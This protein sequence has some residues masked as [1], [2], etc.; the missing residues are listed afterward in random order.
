MP[1]FPMFVDLKDKTVLIAGGGSVALRKLQKL[2]P[3]GVSPTVVAPDI[4]PEL[5]AFPGVKLH[6]RAFRPS[7][8]RPRPVLVIAATNDREVN[9][10]ISM[11]CKKRHI[12]VNVAD[13]P[14]LCSFVFPALVQRGEFS[15]GISTG[16]ASPTAAVYFKERLTELLPENL[17]E[18]LIW[19]RSKRQ[20][21]KA[22]I[23]EPERRAA[24]LHRL[25][26]AGIGQTDP[27][28]ANSDTQFRISDEL[29]RSV[30]SDSPPTDEAMEKIIS[31]PVGS[32]ALVGAGC[33]RAD[34]ITLRGLRLL[35]HCQ[36]VVYDDLIDDALLHAAPES[37]L[38]IYMGKRSGSHA[39]SQSEIE[40]KLIE[41]AQAGLQVVRLK[42]G[43][44]YLFGRGGE[45]MLSL[46]AA[47]IPCTEVPGIPSA[48]GIPAEAGIPVTHRG[49]SRSLHIV[50]AHT[51][52]TPDGLPEDFDA[53][54]KLSGTLVFLMGLK[55]LPLITARLIAAGKDGNTPGAVISGGNAPHPAFVRAP[56]AGLAEAAEN[57]GVSA[58]AVILVG[59]VAGLNLF[60][61][62]ERLRE[63]P[64]HIDQ[65]GSGDLFDAMEE[66][67]DHTY[68]MHQTSSDDLFPATEELNN[69]TDH[70]HQTGSDDL[71]A[72]TD[73]LNGHTDHIHQDGLYD[74]CTT[75][76]ISGDHA[77]HTRHKTTGDLLTASGKLKGLCIGITGT[78]A[79]AVKQLTMLQ[80]SGAR[81]LWILR[82]DIKQLPV[83]PALRA[84]DKDPHWIV[85]TSANG[86]A[87]FFRQ[88]AQKEIDRFS[89]SKYN[90]A[91]IG[92]AT[93]NAL[94]G[95]GFQASLCPKLFTSEALA[96]E[97]TAA[98]KPDER[99]LLLRSAIASPTLPDLLQK[100][101]FTVEDVPIYDLECSSFTEPLP[102]MDYLTFSSS[103]GVALF[104]ERYGQI[105]EGT[106]VVCIGGVT[107]KT[108]SQYTDRPFLTAADISAAGIVEAI[109][110]DRFLNIDFL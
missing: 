28:A 24:A 52:D 67:N 54:A 94:A 8:L 33:G 57:A 1:L 40:Q 36:A 20:A 62:R 84:L 103:S 110:R 9:R 66:S 51:A 98:A 86:V 64:E 23:P 104:F 85:F 102:K 70:I 30:K 15:A 82:S 76:E 4:L 80:A 47:G 69:H 65:A 77:G 29:S 60:A 73:G 75:S 11:L 13:D 43:D 68:P 14:A 105:P 10:Y 89:L 39:A 32:V 42:G 56:L 108:L 38:R 95:H 17:E 78:E 50:T 34:L 55:Q 83:E 7:D 46:K 27:F 90:Y 59:N 5:A 81:G 3:Y 79:V 101:G 41:L 21:I 96:A 107:A 35:K 106:R 92:Q 97:L 12:P 99:I 16:G 22:S 26:D 74:T 109:L 44:P 58:P 87:S 48:I 37:A 45:E 100:A 31:P 49:I 2:A 71:P 61:D 19:L 6:R 25:F 72:A 91:V 88:A 53:L 63:H 93:G 18:L